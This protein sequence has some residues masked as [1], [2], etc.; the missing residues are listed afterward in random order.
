MAPILKSLLYDLWFYCI[1]LGAF[2][3]WRYWA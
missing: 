2:S 1:L 3:W